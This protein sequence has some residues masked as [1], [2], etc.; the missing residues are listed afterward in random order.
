VI[1]QGG[2]KTREGRSASRGKLMAG[3][4]RPTQRAML[5][6]LR[7]KVGERIQRTSQ[8]I[9]HHRLFQRDYGDFSL[10]GNSYQERKTAYRALGNTTSTLSGG[11]ESEGSSHK[12]QTIYSSIGKPNE[13]DQES[14][15]AAKKGGNQDKRLPGKKSKWRKCKGGE[16]GEV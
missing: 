11:K 1:R 16:K 6:E 9:D 2:E 7:E 15:E 13:M 10:Q 4:L 14:W 8:Y 3:V 12:R 5:A